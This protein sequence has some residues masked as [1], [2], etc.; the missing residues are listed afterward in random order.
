MP[1]GW[2]KEA[3]INLAKSFLL[4]EDGTRLLQEDEAR[5]IIY[6]GWTKEAK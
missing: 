1:T 5:I 4:A 2:T 3:L 6:T